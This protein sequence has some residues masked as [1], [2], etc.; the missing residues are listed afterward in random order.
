VPLHVEL[1]AAPVHPLSA[2]R[3]TQ[4]TARLWGP[5]GYGLSQDHTL[6]GGRPPGPRRVGHVRADLPETAAL[7]REA[8]TSRS[9]P[10]PC[11]LLGYSLGARVALHVAT[12]E[13]DLESAAWCDRRD[14]RDGGPR[15]AP[16][17]AAG[18]TRPRRPALEGIGGV[19]K[20]F[21]DQ[22]LK[23]PALRPTGRAASR[24]ERRRNTRRGCFEPR[25]AGTALSAVVDDITGLSVPLLAL[26]GPNDTPL[27]GTRAPPRPAG[28]HAATPRS[29]RWRPRRAP[30]G[31]PISSGVISPLA[32]YGLTRRSPMVRRPPVTS[33]KPGRG[34]SMG[35]APL[36]WHRSGARRTGRTASGAAAKGDQRPTAIVLQH[37]QGERHRTRVANVEETGRALDRAEQP[38]S[39][40]LVSL[41]VSM[42]RRLFACRRARGEQPDGKPPPTARTTTESGSRRRAARRPIRRWP[43]DRRRRRP[44]ARPTRI[45]G[46]VLPRVG[47]TDEAAQKPDGD[48]PQGHPSARMRPPHPIRRR[49]PAPPFGTC[50]RRQS[51]GDESHVAPH[52]PR[53]CLA[54]RRG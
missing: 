44:G 12:G 16:A 51:A 43:P 40:L 1:G 39:I 32:R 22:W 5:V 42:S 17:P 46:G 33:C 9:G 49:R 29:S 21:I 41:S 45:A 20:G 53:R 24:P 23:G 8:V 54:P 15:G 10:T 36:P 48:E 2:A 52:A 28:R 18:R 30:G 38:G 11:D 6:V 31:N 4:G 50:R 47:P 7:V 13:S 14:R 19:G 25:L 37:D 26:A 3:F 27:R 35:G 34:A